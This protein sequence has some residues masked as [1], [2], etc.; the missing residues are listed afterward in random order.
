MPELKT[1]HGTQ[2]KRQRFCKLGISFRMVRAKVVFK[3]LFLPNYNLWYIFVDMIKNS[4][5]SLLIL[6]S[7]TSC[8]NKYEPLTIGFDIYSLDTVDNKVAVI[9]HVFGMYQNKITRLTINVY[10]QLPNNLHAVHI[11]EGSCENIGPHWNQGLDFTA[12]Q[13]TS[14]GEPWSKPYI[15]D[16]GN[17]PTDGEGNGALTVY[18]DLWSIGTGDEKDIL[19]KLIVVHNSFTDF[20]MECDTT[21]IPDH[22][23]YNPKIGC[24]IIK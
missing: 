6:V 5:I 10:D 23:H 24:A 13:S 7:L 11:H 16:V 2:D 21:H 4:I 18:T 12:C 17:V 22:T 9:G 3:G 15:G 8:G 19:G 14:M 20:L 1:I